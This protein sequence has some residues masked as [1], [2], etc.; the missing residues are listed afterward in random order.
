MATA[1]PLPSG[2]LYFY[3][4]LLLYTASCLSA[5]ATGLG[6]SEIRRRRC[7]EV[8]RC[9]DSGIRKFRD[10]E[11]RG[12]GDSEIRIFGKI[13]GDSDIPRL[14]GFLCQTEL[15]AAQRSQHTGSPLF[16]LKQTTHHSACLTG[17]SIDCLPF[18]FRVM[19]VVLCFLAATG[20]Q[21]GSRLA[22]WGRQKGAR[23]GSRNA[24]ELRPRLS[25]D[26]EWIVAS[27]WHHFGTSLAPFP[28][29]LCKNSPK[30]K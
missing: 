19:V 4:A 23:K 28:N 30:S 11:I 7:S 1:Q 18:R 27:S 12:F 20:S 26:F 25:H 16:P 29:K 15:A 13:F 14:G 6:G 22:P 3:G 8:R 2:C 10:S 21:I 17:A 24:S 5:L 9:S